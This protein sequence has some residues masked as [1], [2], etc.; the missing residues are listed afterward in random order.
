MFCAGKPPECRICGTFAG[1]KQM[2][3]D[4]SGFREL[5]HSKCRPNIF[6]VFSDGISSFQIPQCPPPPLWNGGFASQTMGI[7]TINKMLPARNIS[8]DPMMKP[9]CVMVLL[10]M[11]RV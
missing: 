2:G 6:P 7:R 1:A 8:F 11:P 5:L 3:R 4:Y 10:M 9:C